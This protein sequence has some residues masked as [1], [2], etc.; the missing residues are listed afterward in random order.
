MGEDD[1]LQVEEVPQSQEWTPP[2]EWKDVADKFSKAFPSLKTEEVK[3][4]YEQARS[5]AIARNRVATPEH[6]AAFW[7]KAASPISSLD[8]AA[9]NQQY[10]NAKERFD[11]GEADPYDINR[12]AL[13]DRQQQINQNERTPAQSILGSVA[14]V[15][16]AILKYGA[17]GPAALPVM[18]A[19]ATLEGSTARAIE[20]G[21]E[22]Y[23]PKN[24]VP[25]AALGVANAA[26]L[27]RLGKY[28][29]GVANPIAKWGA[30]TAAGVG[31]M[32]AVKFGA[33]LADLVLP[34]EYQTRENFG[35]LGAIAKGKMGDALKQAVEETSVM[36]GFAAAHAFGAITNK[37]EKLRRQGIGEDSPKMKEELGKIV[38][39]VKE[40]VA[41]SKESELF[42]NLG[43]DLPKAPEQATEAPPPPQAPKAYD[44]WNDA[45]LAAITEQMG[46]KGKK[47]RAKVEEW[48]KENRI[49]SELLDQF[50][51]EPAQPQVIRP[52]PP[53]PPAQPSEAESIPAQAPVEA[54]KPAMIDR[55]GGPYA[56]TPHM[57]K[58]MA[59]AD[60]IMSKLPEV[61]EGHTR[62]WR[63][64]R[65]GDKAG[66]A[67]R[68]TDSLE[69]IALPFAKGYE[70]SL[71]YVDVPTK[72]LP[73]PNAHE[74]NAWNLSAD[75][76]KKAKDAASFAK[77]PPQA[78]VVEAPVSEVTPD[79]VSEAKAVTPEKPGTAFERMES[80]VEQLDQARKEQRQS[81]DKVASEKKIQALEN[82]M[83]D[84]HR[85]AGLEDVR[86][87]FED[88][89]LTP[90]ERHIIEQRN[91]G[92]SQPSIGADPEVML[93]GRTKPYTRENIRQIEKGA[94]EKLGVDKASIET[95]V[96]Q[97]EKAGVVDDA[98]DHAKRLNAGEVRADP[99]KVKARARDRKIQNAEESLSNRWDSYLT[100][101][102]K[103]DAFAALSPKDAERLKEILGARYREGPPKESLGELLGLQQGAEPGPEKTKGKEVN[104]E[105]KAQAVEEANQALKEAGQAGA[106]PADIEQADRQARERVAAKIGVKPEELDAIA[107]QR[108]ATPER[109]PEPGALVASGTVPGGGG[110][111]VGLLSKA[112]LWREATPLEKANLVKHVEAMAN[113]GMT[114][115]EAVDWINDAAKSAESYFK[116]HAQPD[117][118]KSLPAAP[119]RP[120]TNAERSA[121]PER[122]SEPGSNGESIRRFLTDESGAINL[123]KLGFGEDRLPP[124]TPKFKLPRGEEGELQGFALRDLAG[125][126]YGLYTSQ[127]EAIDAAN[128][129][130]KL[131]Q[132]RG[133]ENEFGAVEVFGP[134]KPAHEIKLKEFGQSLGNAEQG[135]LANQFKKAASDF[136]AD[137]SGAVN[138]KD[139][140]ALMEDAWDKTQAVRENTGRFIRELAGQ[141]FPA[142]HRLSEKIGNA[143]AR[144]AS[145]RTFVQQAAP[146][147]IDKVMGPNA[148]PELRKLWG[149]ALAELRL[150]YAKAAFLANG[151]PQASANVS[152]VIGQKDSLLKSDADFLK[153]ASSPEF[154]SMLDRYRTEFVPVME[155]AFRK[156]QGLEPTDPINTFT[157][158]PGLPVSFQG[159]DRGIA[160][161]SARGS[162][163]APKARKLGAA[164]EAT[165]SGEYKTDLGSII[166]DT[167]NS[168]IELAN[169]ADLYRNIVE[170]GQGEWRKPGPERVDLPN[171]ETARKIPDVNPPRGT[172]AAKAG[173]TSLYVNEK[174]YN[175][176]LNALNMKEPGPMTKVMK[177]VT[178]PFNSTSIASTVE[179]AYH[180]LNQLTFAATKP[181]VRLGDIWRNLSD[182]IMDKPE[183]RKK[184]MDIAEIG[185]LKPTYHSTEPGILD[186]LGAPGKAVSKTL[187]AGARA[188]DAISDVMR[189]SAS[190]AFDRL[191]SKGLA[192]PSESNK[193]NFINQLG[194][195]ERRAQAGAV[196][197]L[198]D[199]GVGPFATAGTNYLTQGVRSLFLDPGVKA[200]SLY[201]AAK[202]RANVLGRIGAGIGLTLAYNYL[203][204]GRVD[205]DEK[206]PLGSI[207]VRETN[208]KT[209]S[210]DLAAPFLWKRGLRAVGLLSLLEG[211][212]ADV[213]ATSYLDKSVHDIGHSLVH[214]AMGPAAQFAWTAFTGN[215]GVGMP[216]AEKA[217]E[218]ESK[219]AKQLKAAVANANPVIGTMGG[220]NSPG[221][222][223]TT[224]EKI[225]EL[226][227]PYGL[228]Y[229]EK[230]VA[231]RGR[232]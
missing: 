47:S 16:G 199:S 212:R 25:A 182:R 186:K 152:T 94:L 84:L 6:P 219:A 150:R 204:W 48:L 19:E 17:L 8:N 73:T 3:R 103:D 10:K 156:A 64:E 174:M 53:A 56:D 4:H 30:S 107:E 77:A 76:A 93:K 224:E 225:N 66:E 123:E 111:V 24:L 192:V 129:F 151:D 207:K 23:S 184:L 169:K 82:Q 83:M 59:E 181:G 223:K 203:R 231:G 154:K 27:G 12:I 138:L 88:A 135:G 143:M 51:E 61:P 43:I 155:S 114:A 65:P 97:D 86:E 106:T 21:G 202:L 221:K 1:R 146:Y 148:T 128:K 69:G 206:T 5:L 37:Y 176:V 39:E 92:R 87:V 137:D 68:F 211:E 38:D 34:P 57:R 157:Q 185:A 208:G 101:L 90:R 45:D 201:A 105:A 191:V 147:Y 163:S 189:A 46:M 102:E 173:E 40:Q 140:Q 125:K 122:V 91:L 75:V 127:Q 62:L 195:Y 131:Y 63:G 15:P 20:Q 162:L 230:P 196:Q 70:G 179:F 67:T 226:L 166:E 142:A 153:V 229:R 115:Q 209:V 165:L 42:Q 58:I 11:R 175:E 158:I 222:T 100:E 160:G 9:V 170:E 79:I 136:V 149:E 205:G 26:V 130:T 210:F 117:D 13:F 104:E 133:K 126:E 161:G 35:I 200:P 54:K 113:N 55:P 164:R 44:R 172:Q 180:S 134:D 193:R 49:S 132:E 96:R 227:G 183:F 119:G 110:G 108:S 109:V 139:I 14:S 7:I 178:K 232:H 71:R 220:F 120:L 72:D 194:Q 2:P 144:L 217:K 36:G 29:K 89:G 188:L 81:L 33:G 171:G 118:L 145:S 52:E 31:E 141:S 78:P 177:A 197:L 41:G 60:A 187:S 168:R 228:K 214:P 32:E 116:E 95:L 74:P 159:I 50:Q 190:D 18:A 213:P 216:I 121:A 215:N 85:E 28:T 80:L 99:K 198:R 124:K 22:F 112:S 167:L 98:L 218:G